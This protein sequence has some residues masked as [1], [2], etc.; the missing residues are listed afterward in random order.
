MRDLYHPKTLE[1]SVDGRP[2][3]DGF[4][5]ISRAISLVPQ[6]PEIF[7]TT[8]ME[9]ITLGAEYEHDFVR[10]FT[11]IACFTDVA[12]KLPHGLETSI[13][14][15]GVNLSGGQ[16]QRLALSRGLLACHDKDIILLDEPTSSLDTATEMR[17]YQNIFGAF[18]GKTIISTIHRL[19][20]LPL[21]DKIYFFDQ[22]RIAGKG[23]LQE[24]LSTNAQFQDLWQQGILASEQLASAPNGK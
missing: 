18:K 22:G 12:E 23:T 20:L 24:L 14:E 2:I 5:G 8:I 9:N 21:F 19:H 4:G 11:D 16:Q 15:K 7:A 10:H 3:Q 6:N 17:V 13:K 1:L